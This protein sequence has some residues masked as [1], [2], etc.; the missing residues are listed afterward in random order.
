MRVLHVAALGLA[1]HA[2]RVPIPQGAE[3]GG[4]FL[5]TN[6]AQQTRAFQS[7]GSAALVDAAGWPLSDCETVVFDARPFPEW[8]C[9]SDPTQCVDDPWVRGIPLFGTYFFSL[10]GKATVTKGDDPGAH[11][12]VLDNV[13]FDPSS[14]T[15]SGYFTLPEG[16]TALAELTF[17]ATQRTAASPANSGFTNLRIMRPGHTGDADRAWS[18]ELLAMCAPLDHLRFMGI[19]GTNNQA[20]YYGDV[21]HHYLEWTDRCLPSDAQWPNSLRPGCWGMPWEDVVSVSRASGKGVWVNIPVSGTLGL[22]A[23]G[24]ANLTT[25]AGQWAQLLKSGNAATG[26]AG[27]PDAAPIYVEHSN[28]RGQCARARARAA[29]CPFLTPH[30]ARTRPLH[31]GARHRRYGISGECGVSCGSL[32]ARAAAAG[33]AS[34]PHPRAFLLRQLLAIRMEQIGGYG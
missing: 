29:P 14:F 28:A 5:Y 22:L 17:A 1:A 30:S 19:T 4:T 12:V 34:L 10:Q 9:P 8:Q 16:A 21:G 7:N 11:A 23:D 15:T 13:T 32:R 27:V 18:P 20:G 2:A 3:F 33:C 31:V 6:I 25:Y 26:G 24:S